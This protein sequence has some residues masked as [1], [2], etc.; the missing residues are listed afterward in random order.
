[1]SM[2]SSREVNEAILA[3]KNITKECKIKTVS[4]QALALAVIEHD[5]FKDVFKGEYNVLHNRL[6]KEVKKFAEN[7][8]T[9]TNDCDQPLFAVLNSVI[10]RLAFSFP[11]ENN[12]IHFSALFLASCTKTREFSF[13]S[14]LRQCKIDKDAIYL[15]L[16]NAERKMLGLEPLSINDTDIIDVDLSDGTPKYI[17]RNVGTFN[18]PDIPKGKGSSLSEEEAEWLSK[19]AKDLILEAKMHPEPFVGRE[20]VVEKTMLTL[21]KKKK[22][23]PIHIGEPGI[24]KTAVTYGLAKRI[25]DGKVPRTLK[26]ANLYEMNV[27]ALLAGTRYRGDFEERLKTF[28]NLVTKMYKPII[29]IDEIHMLIGCGSGDGSSMDAANILK[30]YLTTGKIKFIGATTHNEYRKYF[31]R[32]SA[33][34]RRFQP[35]KIDEPSVEDAVKIL[36]GVKED[37][38]TYHKKT[39]TDEAIRTAVVMSDKLIHDR[40]LPDKAIDFLDIAG[41]KFNLHPELGTTIDE[42]AMEDIILENCNIK[43][44]DSGTDT[45]EKLRNLKPAIREKIFGQDEAIDKV[46]DAIQLKSLGLGYTDKPLSFLFVGPSGVGKTE[47]A[48]IIAEKAHL[49]FVRFDMSEYSDMHS[50]SKLFGTSAGFVGYDDGGILTNKILEKPHCLLLLD[51]VEKAH[52]DIYKTFLQIF[53]YGMLTDSKGRKVDFNNTVIIMT[54]NA[55]SQNV[56]K[57]GIGFNAESTHADAMQEALNSFFS[58]EF[59]GRLSAIV[60]F[61]KL[62]K[63]IVLDIVNKEL[64][65]LNE[66][67]I[68]QDINAVFTMECVEELAKRSQ[69]SPYGA[70][71]I[72]KV[73][74]NEI[75]R[76][77]AKSIIDGTICKNPIITYEDDAFKVKEEASILLPS[78]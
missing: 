76:L 42:K 19:F 52:P 26:G 15:D 12:V 49:D 31:E 41:A 4:M 20:D 38:E 27:P 16:R 66:K 45:V 50:T 2:K 77:I 58:T 32:D 22:G 14:I 23:N 36:M 40:F 78:K 67:L 5:R 30:P 46:V 71:E 54:S 63:T 65:I 21:C 57:A 68:K 8:E 11:D 51:E 28:L 18:D 75:S 53:D 29:F 73:I 9:N 56:D 64:G 74:N 17:K 43:D 48:K 7:N 59:R 24:G 3:S 70:R 34:V 60:E 69:N 72:R 25:S 35:I 39:F 44:K 6:E 47:L 1:M 10:M 37:F 13:D 55:G 61:K 33:L 62:D